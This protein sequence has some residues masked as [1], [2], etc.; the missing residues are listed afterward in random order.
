MNR[1]KESYTCWRMLIIPALK[2]RGGGLLQIQGQLRLH[3]EFPWAA[4][5]KPVSKIKKP[6]TNK[7]LQTGQPQGG[8][9]RL[10]F[11]FQV[12]PPG[13]ISTRESMGND[14]SGSCYSLLI[15]Q[16]WSHDSAYPNFWQGAK[17]DGKG[18]YP[19]GWPPSLQSNWSLPRRRGLGRNWK[20]HPS[21][22]A[23][24]MSPPLRPFSITPLSQHPWLGVGF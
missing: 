21:V 9:Q 11:G 1:W 17:D 23:A 14:L 8:G 15:G 7:K 24:L 4:Q 20:V 22:A 5:W 16:N 18:D 13:M 6:K 12:S 2:R 10:L 19:K 3:N